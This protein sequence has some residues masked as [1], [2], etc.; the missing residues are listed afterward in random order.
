[1]TKKHTQNMISLVKNCWQP[2]FGDDVF[3]DELDKPTLDYFFFF[4]YC[5]KGLK[6]GTVN[7]AINVGSRAMEYLFENG[8]IEKTPMFG[9]EK[10]SK[11]SLDRA[12]SHSYS[13]L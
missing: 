8:K 2:Y 13:D 10:T 6:G 5:E 11:Y 4:L 1:M 7:K 9:V 3:V 12:R